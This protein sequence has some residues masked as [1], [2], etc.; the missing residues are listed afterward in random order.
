M[1]IEIKKLSPDLLE[2]FLYFFDN[3]AFTDNH[4]FAL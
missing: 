4:H 2:D 3:T 1:D